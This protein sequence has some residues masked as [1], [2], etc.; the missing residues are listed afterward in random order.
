[1]PPAA[2]SRGGAE[3][4]ASA[5]A[6]AA[7]I[8][9]DRQYYAGLPLGLLRPL[10]LDYGAAAAPG[11]RRYLT[12]FLHRHL[13]MRLPEAQSAAELALEGGHA[14]RLSGGSSGSSS[15]GAGGSGSP[16]V[17]WEKPF[18]NRPEAPFWYAHVES[19][20]VARAIAARSMLTKV[21]LEVWGEAESLQGLQAA[22]AAYPEEERVKWGAPDQSFKFVVDTWGCTYTMSQQIDLIES[23]EG[24]T[25]FQ[26]RI[27]LRTPQ[28]RFWLIVVK[29]N[30]RG[31]PLLPDRYYFGREVAAGDRSAVHTY[32][33]RRRR[34]L[35]PTSMDTE[36]AFLMCNM[37]KVRRCSLVLDPFVGTGS[38]L[39]PAAHLG[40]MT[41]GADIDIRVIKLGKKDKAGRHVNVW[42]NFRD[43][44]LPPPLGLLR[45]DL[46]TAPFRTGLEEVL[47]AIVCDPPYG[48][49][50]GG[51]KSVAKDRLITK[52]ES[53]IPSTD[54]YT[55]A[56][57]LHDLLDAAARLLRPGGRLAYFMPSAPGFYFEE[58]VPR[59][60]ALGM[61]ANCEQ[62]LTTRYSRR[63]I[64]M[65]KIRAYDAAEAAAY[66]EQRGPPKMS[67]DDMHEYVYK[68]PA[69]LAAE[70]GISLA[71][72]R[73]AQAA[74]I[75][76]H[77][78]KNI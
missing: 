48:V 9:E 63:L 65:E 58:E 43:Y 77:R 55:L 7:E 22:V 30:G 74:R 36:M 37:C 64:V 1:M 14:A 61:V 76:R 23:M 44:G 57:C 38:I 12:Y 6:T 70:A 21:V 18:D 34:Y 60:P 47:D 28:N 33:L 35:G 68:S 67:V 52:P 72:H 59:H 15:A 25:R 40:A 39:I 31:L 50:A 20:D 53:Y 51:R 13:E 8:E 41:L 5:S 49:R 71:E 45:C 56:E 27:D 78:G 46:H 73:A 29:S 16:A 3:P 54:P 24:C 32:D 75:P 2:E 11:R 69:E 66:F 62:M 10:V 17:I 4:A 19:E 42:T 26:G